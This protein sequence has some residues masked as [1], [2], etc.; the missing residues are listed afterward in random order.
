M[1]KVLVVDDHELVQAGL[2]RLLDQ[3]DDIVV[4]GVAGS[5]PDAVDS[6]RSLAPDVILMDL[7]MPGMDGAEATRQILAQRPD[8]RVVMLTA[9]TEAERVMDALNAGAVGYLAKDADPRTLIDA[10]RSAAGGESPLDPRAARALLDNRTAPQTVN[11]VLS[12]REIEVLS[13]VAAGLP[14]KQIARELQITEKTVK[15]H[16]TKIYAQIGVSDR[17]QAALW[18]VENEMVDRPSR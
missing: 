12:D 11:P 9:H 14:N 4:C 18:A 13:H 17:T 10:V 1:I 16:L 5:G 3:A 6:D 8:A 15:A 7:S 2:V